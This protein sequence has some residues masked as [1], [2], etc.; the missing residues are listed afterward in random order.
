MKM[1]SETR[2]ALRGGPADGLWFWFSRPADNPLE[3][4][5]VGV[6]M[7]ESGPSYDYEYDNSGSPNCDYQGVAVEEGD[8]E[9]EDALAQ[10]STRR[11]EFTMIDG[12][13]ARRTRIVC[14][15]GPSDGLELTLVYPRS[16]TLAG[17]GTYRRTPEGEHAPGLEH[18]YELVPAWQEPGDLALEVLLFV[19]TGAEGANAQSSAAGD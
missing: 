12:T 5:A 19:Y 18:N 14:D 10:W 17:I 15:R 1:F 13:P 9:E 16:I 4:E 2:Y 3:V 8:E 7:G 11:V 6:R